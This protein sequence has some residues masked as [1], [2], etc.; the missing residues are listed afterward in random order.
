MYTLKPKKGNIMEKYLTYEQFGAIGDGVHDDQDAIIAC[1]EEANRQNIP[2]KAKDGATYYVGGKSKAAVIKTD[3]DFGKAHFIIDDIELEDIKSYVFSIESDYNF[4]PVEIPTLI[5]GQKKLDVGKSGSYLVRVY[6]D[7]H[8]VFI[9]KGLNMNNGIATQ[10][11]FLVDSEGNISPSVNFDYPTVSRAD[12]RCT[13]DAP[14]TVRGG[15][16]T[17]VA[18]QQESYYRYHQRGFHIVRSHVTICDFEH[19]VEGE[20]DHGAPYHGFIRSDNAVDLTVKNA[21]VTSRRTYWTESK[22]PG[23]PVPMG[24]YDLSFWAS[25]NV[26]CINVKQTR[27]IV[28]GRYW[29]V[30]TS[31]FCKNLHIEDCVFSRFDA[32]MG[33]TDFVIKNCRL[34]HQGV[35]LIGFGTGIIENTEVNSGA[36]FS[37]R[38][39]YGAT[40]TGTV[41]IKNCAWNPRGANSAIFSSWNEEDHDFGYFCCEPERITVD[42]LH[43]NDSSLGDKPVYLLPK[44]TN[45]PVTDEKLAPYGRVKEYV[46]NGLTTERGGK[47]ELCERPELYPEVNVVM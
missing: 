40:W 26:K 12:M 45:A 35:Q 44:F 6:D 31:N 14:I 46:V 36:F 19:Y 32:H 41:S 4:E 38:P 28:D 2:V 42:G 5:R 21:I 7:S 11:I 23:K 16:F 15:V 20:L 27:D 24:T 17:T 3:V 8:P 29:G 34:G 43:V 37:L 13:D 30:Y 25:I 39:D 18:N 33:V 1:H 22:I 9:R 10:D 47:V